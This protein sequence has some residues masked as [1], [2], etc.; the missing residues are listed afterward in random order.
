MMS[1][2]PS[3]RVIAVVFWL[4]ALASLPILMPPPGWD[5]RVYVNAIHSLQ[6]GHDPYADGIAVQRAFHNRIGAHS[7]WPPPFT[8]VY[9][10]LTLPLLRLIG[11]I[12]LDF[13]G[14]VYWLLFAA[15]FLAMVLV[16]LGAAEPAERPVFALV[17]PAAIFFP[18]LLETKVIFSG[19]LVYIL[20]GLTLATAWLGW[21][22]GTWSWFYLATL[23]AS[24]FKAPLLTLL[25]I[26]ALSARRQWLPACATAAIGLALF[27]VQPLIWPSMF[28]N[29]LE[30]VSLQFS[31]NHDF[32]L[33]PAGLLGNI[34]FQRQLPYSAASTACYIAYA[35]PTL[36]VLVYLARR[37]FAGQISLQ[38]WIPVMLLG[39]ILLNPRIKEYDVA[40]L[41]VPMAMILWRFVGRGRTP[42][43]TGIAAFVFL[44]A[45]NAVGAT[46]EV[47]W[48]LT[49]GILLVGLFIAGTWDLLRAPSE[50]DA[51]AGAAHGDG[52]LFSAVLTQNNT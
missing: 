25:M 13:S 37:Y 24:C 34:L 18:G 5:L 43:Q 39:V 7:I 12:P 38:R 6:A 52:R 14:T 11:K 1:R 40:L 23:G 32:G 51:A 33:S 9:S 49:E 45:V 26:P 17:A 27:A 19:N 20:Y 44:A 2:L 21:R 3:Y 15:G 16:T 36:G 29:Y 8:Y 28:G 46:A 30:A 50:R 35:A 41:S 22:R 48:K 47:M 31:Y 42:L 10:P 4:L